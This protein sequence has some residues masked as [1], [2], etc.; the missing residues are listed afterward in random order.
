MHTRALILFL[1]AS[2]GISVAQSG[3]IAGD[4]VDDG[5]SPLAEMRVDISEPT[6]AL[7]RSTHS[8]EHGHFLLKGL[9]SGNYDIVTHNE[10]L[11]YPDSNDWDFSRNIGRLSVTVAESE[12]C[13]PVKIQRGPRAGRLRLKLTDSS[14]G[15][16]IEKPE[17]NFRRADGYAW[18]EISLNGMDLLVPPSKPLEVRVGAK[19]YEPSQILRITPLQPGEVREF[20]WALQKIGVG[21]LSGTILD[22][23]N[24]PVPKILVQPL[25]LHN[26]LNAKVPL[27]ARTDEQGRFEIR[28]LHLGIYQLTVDDKKRG[29]DGFSTMK[30]Y[31]QMA[32]ATVLAST[33]CTD[34]TVQ[35]TSPS[36]TLHAEIVDATTQQPVKDFKLRVKSAIPEEWWYVE[37]RTGET[38][39]PSNRPCSIEVEAEGY[40]KSPALS[41]GTFQGSEVR[42]L[43]IELHPVQ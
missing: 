10:S 8:D 16:P 30:I 20:T 3:C 31:G 33:S 21:C 34:I 29:Y 4:I 26:E 11:G 14:T 1:T 12:E 27:S 13:T 36:A 37:S 28:D 24:I 41:L 5:G 15:E 22:A 39:V 42:Q 19:G 43:K 18:N 2:C 17:A 23:G 38:L 7:Y 6:H 25:L 9:P 32:Q 35:L 40:Q